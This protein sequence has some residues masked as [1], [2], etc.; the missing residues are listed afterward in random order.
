MGHL[1][2]TDQIADDGAGSLAAGTQL[3]GGAFTIQQFL[4]RGAFGVVY[5][6]IDPLGRHVAIKE[7]F[8]GT[9][10]QRHGNVVTPVTP[11]ASGALR[12]MAARFVAEAQIQAKI[13]HA[14]VP[15][16]HHLFSE[17]NTHYLAM[18][19]V[20]GPDALCAL[21]NDPKRMNSI[22]L[23]AGLI[24]CLDALVAIHGAQIAHRDIKPD[25]LMIDEH[26]A[27]Q[28]IDFG[29]ACAFDDPNPPSLGT[30]SQYA[31]PTANE[32]IDQRDDLF[33][34]GASFY[35]LITG[36]PPP[37][38]SERMS[39]RKDPYRALAKVRRDFDVT[40]LTAIDDA[41]SLDPDVRPQTAKDWHALVTGYKIPKTHAIPADFA[42]DTD[43]SSLV[44]EV[45][46]AVSTPP[47]VTCAK[48]EAPAP[49]PKLV[50]VF[51][52][53]ILDIDVWSAQQDP[54]SPE[55]FRTKPAGGLIKAIAQSVLPSRKSQH[56]LSTIK[57]EWSQ[58]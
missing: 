53:P 26:D 14:N 58:Q 52:D 41:L 23:R 21:L 25:N 37:R 34:L 24:D 56:L 7:C 57:S 13:Y 20:N 30:P 46:E 11:A 54:R 40:F 1:A 38:A 15:A 9:I 47:P 29:N 4:M 10:A 2:Q 27:F 22:T 36:H 12:K 17:N 45:N 19:W 42:P 5:R 18:P 33:S 6:A 49:Q 32:R 8:P 28:I 31:A 50:D 51:G 44:A 3:D 35:Q 43:L 39:A 48:I 55:P 16:P